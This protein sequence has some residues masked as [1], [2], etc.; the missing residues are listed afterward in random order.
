[1]TV[2]LRKVQVTQM[3]NSE[4]KVW[5]LSLV[6]VF[7]IAAALGAVIATDHVGGNPV[8]AAATTFAATLTLG[9]GVIAFVLT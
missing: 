5:A 7:A 8:S 6:T 3:K 4:R 9:L 1:M 2:D